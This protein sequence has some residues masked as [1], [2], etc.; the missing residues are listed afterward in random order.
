MLNGGALGAV[1]SG[2]VP[3]LDQLMNPSLPLPA[4]IDGWDTANFGYWMRAPTASGISTDTMSQLKLE[5]T[6]SGSA[7]SSSLTISAGDQSKGTG[8]WMGVIQHDDGTYGIYAISSLAAGV[9]TVFPN[10][11]AAVTNQTMTNAGGTV[12]GQHFTQPGFA[13][14]ANRVFNTTR[15]MGYRNR[16]IAQWRGPTGTKTDWTNIGGLGSGQYAMGTLNNIISESSVRSYQAFVSR[17]RTVLTAT[18]TSPRTGKGVSRSF[19]LNGKSGVCEV[20]AS[21]AFYAAGA[22]AGF[23]PFNVTLKVD[24]TEFYNH[25]FTENDGLVRILQDFPAG[26]TGQA[27]LTFS[28]DTPTSLANLVVDSVTWWVYDRTPVGWAWSDSV[29]DKNANLV[30]IGDSWTTF[31]P[32]LSSVDGILGRTLQALMTGAGGSGTV[33]SV[34]VAGTGAEYSQAKFES[35]VAPLAPS[36]VVINDFTNDHNSYGD[37]GYARWLNALYRVGRMCQNI[38]ARPIFIMPE[39]T[40]AFSQ[41]IGHGIWADA[42]GAGARWAQ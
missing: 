8:N 41:A 2:K 28:D 9:C 15:R 23:W 30:V 35:V 4:F 29:I 10:L 32:N 1:V 25:T 22:G 27:I 42:L 19:D 7:G 37:S 16:W 18:P 34:G 36:Q 11:R 17:A 14:L 40:Q 6:V 31:Y 12:N 5:Y 3:L 26:T 38:G 13:A 21:C 39:P 24:G 20:I 33:T